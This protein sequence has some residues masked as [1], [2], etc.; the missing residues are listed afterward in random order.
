MTH[1]LGDALAALERDI[2][3]EAIGDHKVDVF[4]EDAVTLD[5]TDIVQAAAR[6]QLM[7]LLDLLV[8]L[9][10]FLADIEERDLGPGDSI[11]GTRPAHC[12]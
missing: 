10:L 2:A 6:Q 3:D 8:A 9:D 1:E 4:Q 7:S 12:P 11:D 5:V